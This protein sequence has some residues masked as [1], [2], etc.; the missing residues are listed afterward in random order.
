MNRSAK[1]FYCS[2]SKLDSYLLL[3]P[4]D[5]EVTGLFLTDPDRPSNF[6]W[7]AAA[8]NLNAGAGEG[9]RTLN[10]RITNP[11]LYQLSYASLSI[12]PWAIGRH[13]PPEAVPMSLIVLKWS[14]TDY[15]PAISPLASA[16]D[17]STRPREDFCNRHPICPS[18]NHRVTSERRSRS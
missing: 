13:R 10:L 7:F 12:Q 9:T 18:G 4:K 8:S 14:A 15:R 16:S 11:M 5:L 17:S 3:I 2:G 1:F 6:V